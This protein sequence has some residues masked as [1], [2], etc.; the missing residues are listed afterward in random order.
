MLLIVGDGSERPRL[1]ML[2]VR[3]GAATACCFL[4]HRDDIIDLHYAF[5]LLVQSSDYEG[6]PNAVLEAMAM[7]TPIVATEVGGT[8]ELVHDRVHAL[9]TPAGD[10]K[11]L[12]EAI[13][14]TL[15]YPGVTAQRVAAARRRVE[16][17]L[18]FEA[19]Q[20]ALETVY[21]ELAAKR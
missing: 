7:E 21:L 3:L 10:A 17:E 15:S 12:A 1:E 18:S 14:A 5:D 8:R 20:R 11:A 4:G 13:E 19:R 6:T 16:A 9:L 2:A